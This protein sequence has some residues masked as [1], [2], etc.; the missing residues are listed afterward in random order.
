MSAG[1][2]REGAGR[3]ALGPQNKQQRVVFYV[4]PETAGKIEA[5]KSG[6]VNVKEHLERMIENLS[7]N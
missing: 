4:A 6:G 2:K 7:T 5:L 3:K 1:G